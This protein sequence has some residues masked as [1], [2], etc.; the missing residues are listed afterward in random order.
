MLRTV[1]SPRPSRKFEAQE[2]ACWNGVY[3]C[4]SSTLMQP[5]HEDHLRQWG[6]KG[7][8]VVES[9]LDPG[10]DTVNINAEIDLQHAIDMP[11]NPEIDSV[12]QV[13]CELVV[14]VIV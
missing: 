8:S 3:R 14:V 4:R 5:L 2:T 9:N 10:I 13:L 6:V 11:G 1:I 12:V 7:D